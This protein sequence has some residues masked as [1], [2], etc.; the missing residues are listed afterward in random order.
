VTAIVAA[1][2]LTAGL[3]AEAT[4]GR[5]AVGPAD[6]AFAAVSTD[7]RALPAGALFIALAGPRFDAHAFVEDV[8][9]RGAAGVI[10]SR[11]PA[12]AGGAAVVVVDDTLEALQRLARIVRR[13]S[14]ARVVA[15]TGSAG[16]TTTKEVAAELLSAKYRVFRNPGNLNNHIGLPLSLLE[17]RHGPEVAVVELGMN[18]HGEIRELVRIAEPDIRVWT[19]VGDAHVGHFASMDAIADAKAEIL[20]DARAGDLVVANADDPL[21]MRHVAR[22]PG[23]RLLFG[24]G[25]DLELPVTGRRAPVPGNSRSDP[26]IRAERVVDR[27]FDG[28][29][30]EVETPAGRL[31]LR[32]PLAGR[33]QLSNVLAAVAVATELGVPLAAIEERAAGLRPVGRRGAVTTLAGG[34][35]LID[36]S[37]NASPAATRAMLSALASTAA[38]GRR[39]AVLGEMLELG[40][41]ALSLHEA[42]G[43]AAAAAGVD[44]LVAVGG[45]AADG[46]Q[47][48]A[49]AAGMSL[50]RIHRFQTSDEA[51]AFVPSLV[52]PGDLVLV[53]GSRGTRTD[54]IADR[55]KAGA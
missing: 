41:S 21:V 22:F 46:L 44:T 34:A 9:A 10:V 28:T 8:I 51:A 31:H 15:I 6:R 13:R 37:Y 17:L 53:K 38:A 18:H 24:L 49:A 19:N 11:M 16:K 29:E 7:S 32:V 4:G 5:L 1:F 48:G 36:D 43:R 14:A 3:V 42:C 39:I 20:E 54:L 55:L 45:P 47:A 50:D 23:R 35:R 27:G 33:A 12:D 26:S 52:A 40:D 2:A 30:C 25:S